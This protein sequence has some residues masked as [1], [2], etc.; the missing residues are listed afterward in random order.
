VR[1]GRRLRIGDAG[2]LAEQVTRSATVNAH[3]EA[4]ALDLGVDEGVIT[5]GASGPTSFSGD[6]D[7][8]AQTSFHGNEVTT[9]G[10]SGLRVTADN[11]VVEA[12]A[13]VASEAVIRVSLK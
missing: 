3:G 7:D 2:F 11:V 9:I 5:I 1:I 13:V 10:H 12:L 6:G 4:V 8:Q